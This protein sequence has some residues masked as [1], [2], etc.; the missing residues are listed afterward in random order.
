MFS[1]ETLNKKLAKARTKFNKKMRGQQRRELA[2]T[3][4]GLNWFLCNDFK[5]GCAL[6]LKDEKID[7]LIELS[8]IKI[9]NKQPYK[10]RRSRT[11]SPNG[12]PCWVCKTNK[13]TC[14]HHII[15]IKNGG[16]DS[17]INRIPICDSC[18]IEIHPWM[19]PK[20]NNEVFDEMYLNSV[21]KD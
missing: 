18:H 6:K 19:A 17:G 16:Y 11:H 14:Q 21:N 13:A 12:K 8:K 5:K 4:F 20:V 9:N 7:K 10:R 15:Q 3:E 1:D 2:K